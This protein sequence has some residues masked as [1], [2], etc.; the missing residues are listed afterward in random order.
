MS[1]LLLIHNSDTLFET[2]KPA[3]DKR[4]NFY[5]YTDRFCSHQGTSKYLYIFAV[6]PVADNV[7]L[8]S[9]STAQDFDS[10]HKDFLYYRDYCEGKYP[11]LKYAESGIAMSFSELTP[12]ITLMAR[13]YGSGKDDWLQTEFEIIKPHKPF[14]KRVISLFEAPYEELFAGKPIKFTDIPELVD[15]LPDIDNI[16]PFKIIQP[17]S[18]GTYSIDNWLPMTTHASGTWL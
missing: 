11:N 14:K 15:S 17:D 7:E 18:N 6:D 12:V 1:K 9:R 16:L 5:W 4:P 3:S 13:S 2:L 10:L 8:R